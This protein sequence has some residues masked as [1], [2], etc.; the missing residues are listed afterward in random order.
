MTVAAGPV[1]R[2]SAPTDTRQRRIAYWVTTALV[3]L[4]LAGGGIADVLRTDTVVAG[5]TH[6]GYPVYFIV[7]I[8]IWKLLGTAALLAPAFPR[9]KEWAYA[10]AIFNFTGAAIS[11]AA[12]S[13]PPIKLL[14]PLL[15]AA[16][17]IASWTLRP[18]TRRL[19]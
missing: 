10:G 1:P 2:A 8:G 3:A 7:L 9:L 19:A 4:A 17:A 16:L 15:L 13:D 5:M 6:L 14:A 12:S 18:S 11:H